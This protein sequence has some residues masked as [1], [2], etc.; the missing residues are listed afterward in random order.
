VTA[1]DERASYAIEPISGQPADDACGHADDARGMEQADNAP[2]PPIPPPVVGWRLTM[3][4][5]G[6]SV[7]QHE[8]GTFDEAQRAGV[9]WLQQHG[10]ESISQRW[11]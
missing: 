8:C 6:R 5:D 3:Q 7:E 10:S 4:R 11:F 1:M 2:L 9:A